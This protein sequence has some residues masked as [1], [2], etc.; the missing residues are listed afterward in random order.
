MLILSWK[1]NFRWPK[2]LIA[3]IES[4]EPY[5]V[6]L[7]DVSRDSADDWVKRLKGVG[8]VDIDLGAEGFS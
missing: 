4:T 6:T 7:Q 2:K 3:K 5:I 8:L 1:A